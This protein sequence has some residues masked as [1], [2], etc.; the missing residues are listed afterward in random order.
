MALISDLF[1]KLRDTVG[2]P[3]LV[4]VAWAFLVVEFGKSAR[5]LYADT[6]YVALVAAG[7]FALGV[8]VGLLHVMETAFH[9]NPR[10]AFMSALIA[11]VCAGLVVGTVYGKCQT[12]GC[13]GWD[14]VLGF[15][16]ILLSIPPAIVFGLVL[17]FCDPRAT[18][19]LGGRIAAVV[20]FGTGVMLPVGFLVVDMGLDMQGDYVPFWVVELGVAVFLLV[21]AFIWLWPLPAAVRYARLALLAVLLLV[22]GW[23]VPPL[24]GLTFSKAWLLQTQ[25]Q[26][27]THIGFLTL[28]AGILYLAITANWWLTRWVDRLVAAPPSAVLAPP[29]P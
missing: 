23:V 25:A 28:W 27:G 18:L 13:K 5:A 24:A 3:A 19:S 20:I 2:T 22:F 4:L 14:P 7:L 29:R 26:T 11:G 1:D 9:I 21:E 16:A 6:R 10:Q 12:S 17:A 8:C 15:Q